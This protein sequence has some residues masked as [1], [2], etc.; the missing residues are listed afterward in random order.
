MTRSHERAGSLGS[1]PGD[2][3]P[4]PNQGL[5]EEYPAMSLALRYY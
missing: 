1:G 5:A 3:E 2:G 4:R